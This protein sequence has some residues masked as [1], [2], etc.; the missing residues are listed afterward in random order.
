[1]ATLT[2]ATRRGFALYEY[3]LV[4]VV[5]VVMCMSVT[6]VIVVCM[7]YSGQFFD[8]H[9]KQIKQFN[10]FVPFTRRT[11]AYYTYLFKVNFISLMFIRAILIHVD[12]TSASHGH[13]VVIKHF[14]ETVFHSVNNGMFQS[15][16]E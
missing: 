2:T 6:V 13:I 15:F 4:T 3:I 16:T 12:F 7:Y 14:T 11:D 9:L 5:I 1:M 10:G 8:R